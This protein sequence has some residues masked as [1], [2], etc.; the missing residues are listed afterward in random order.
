MLVA[1]ETVSDLRSNNIAFHT[2]RKIYSNAET[3]E[4]MGR[5]LNS[6]WVGNTVPGYEL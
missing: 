1:G 3:E 5:R 2:R 4:I 6:C